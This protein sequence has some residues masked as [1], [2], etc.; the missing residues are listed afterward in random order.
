MS[1][2]LRIECPCCKTKLV[3]DQETGEILSHETPKVDTDATFEKA[4]ADVQGGGQRR[5]DAF[6]K[7]FQ[8]TKKLDDLLE[9]KFE[10]ARKKAAD[11][12]TPRKNP[13]DWD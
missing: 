2:P 5:E 3:L 10:E 13:L 9:Q 8:K 12:P 1:G 7:A 6:A 4:M 11:D